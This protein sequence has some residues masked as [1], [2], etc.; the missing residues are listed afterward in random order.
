MVVH[1]NGRSWKQVTS[2]ALDVSGDL[3]GVAV[4][5]AGRVWAV[6]GNG[7]A[8]LIVHWNGMAW[9]RVSNPGGGLVYAVT[10]ASGS[11]AW[12]VGE[13]G[14]GNALILRW[15]GKAWSRA[16]VPANP[17]PGHAEFLTSVAATS[18]RNAWAVGYAAGGGAG[19]ILRWN[20]TAWKTV[21]PAG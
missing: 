6:G 7:S 20:G 19:V 15:N 4:T 14:A 10:A 1:W 8:T 3:T 12:A 13:S 5:P 16:R 2:P 18:V 11:N 9:R 21:Q 17:F